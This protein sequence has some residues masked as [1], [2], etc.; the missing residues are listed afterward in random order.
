MAQSYTV[1]W[2]RQAFFKFVEIFPQPNLSPELKSKI[3]QLILIPCFAVS[4][5][6]GEGDKLVG[7]T[8]TPEQDHPENIVSVFITK[9]CFT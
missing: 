1:D 6:R 2:K 5:D 7:S 4:F 9:V 8:P 3:L